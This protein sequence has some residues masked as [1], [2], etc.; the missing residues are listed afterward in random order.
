MI[1][2]IDDYNIE[3]K[4]TLKNAGTSKSKFVLSSDSGKSLLILTAVHMEN[5]DFNVQMVD[6]CLLFDEL[7]IYAAY[8]SA[9]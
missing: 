3:K 8:A 4:Y 2:L 6:K 9:G 1:T 5:L 7:T